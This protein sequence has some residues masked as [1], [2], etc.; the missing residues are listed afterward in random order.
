MVLPSECKEPH[1]AD[2]DCDLVQQELLD[3]ADS[4]ITEGEETSQGS[5]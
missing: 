2:A 5:V 3:T 1:G 4:Q